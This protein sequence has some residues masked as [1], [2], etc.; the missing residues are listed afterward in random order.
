MGAYL[1]KERGLSQAAV[2][3]YVP[4]ID[5][6]LAARFRQTPLNLSQLRVPD[7]TDFV[8]REA[9]KL[10]PGRTVARFR[11]AIFSSLSTTPRKS[12]HRSGH[13]CAHRRPLVVCD[14]AQV[15]SPRCR[16]VLRHSE[17]RTSVGRRNYA[18]LLLLVRLGLRACE[19]VA[20]DLEDI[21]WEKARITIR[22]KGG[23]WLSCHF[24]PM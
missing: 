22:S 18:I 13:L 16:R 17:R 21:D 1:L 12:H 23:R 15:S 5:Q 9:R 4:F 11:P 6:F 8:Q 2:V 14:F 3:N 10:G 7:V 19:I 20:L 24:R